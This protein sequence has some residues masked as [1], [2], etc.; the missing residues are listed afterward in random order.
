MAT[1][2]IRCPGCGANSSSDPDAHGIHVCEFC[3]TRF[4]LAAGAQPVPVEGSAPGGGAK[5]AVLMGGVAVALVLVAAVA[6]AVLLVGAPGPDPGPSLPVLDQLEPIEIAPT[7]VTRQDVVSQAVEAP[8]EPSATFTHHGVLQSS[9]GTFYVLGELENTS[10]FPLGKTKIN[11]V[12]LDAAGKELH[13]DNG[14]STRE[15]LAPGERSP[16]SAIVTEAPKYDALRFE[17]VA[18]KPFYLPPQVQ[19]LRLEPQPLSKERS[20]WTA[21]GKV[22][23]EG[24]TPAEFVNVEIVGRDAEGRVLGVGSTYA[25][26]DV[27]KPGES[28]RYESSLLRF[29]ADPVSIDYVVTGRPAD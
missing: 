21:K 29:T 2:P 22:V 23:N 3:S 5:G 20:F 16:V 1:V 18:T 15:V 14:W 17:V 13:V 9:E 24:D 4:K 19:G 11:I 7:E 26:G 6:G 27:L 10:P 25:D 8:V 12:L 28:A